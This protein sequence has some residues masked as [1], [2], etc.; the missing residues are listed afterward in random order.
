[1]IKRLK[2]N[3]WREFGKHLLDKTDSRLQ[4]QKDFL[5][6]CNEKKAFLDYLNE[7]SLCEGSIGDKNV[8]FEHPFTEREFISPPIDT[9]RKIW[10]EFSSIFADEGG[11]E[12]ASHYGFWGQVVINMIEND[13]IKPEHLAANINGINNTGRDAIGTALGAESEEIVDKCVRRILRSM[14]NE[15]PRGG[16]IIF[17]DFSLGK[18]YWRWQWAEEMSQCI[19]LTKARIL[20]ILD[21]NYYVKFSAKMHSGRSYISSTN[22]LGGLLLYL[23][24]TKDMDQE[25][26][27]QIIDKISYLSAWKAIEIQ[28]CEDNQNEIQKIGDNVSQ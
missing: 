23:D 9:E 27:G 10:S 17:N 11:D 7:S 4:I 22:V 3:S 8:N 16:R 1:M 5:E 12:M 2:E 26:L 20:E 14:C 28:S 15:A 18:A 24:K 25:K 21:P 13:S 19:D 6:A